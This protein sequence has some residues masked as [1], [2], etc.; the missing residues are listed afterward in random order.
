MSAQL[1]QLVFD[2]VL[3]KDAV[4]KI[5]STENVQTILQEHLGGIWAANI[6]VVFPAAWRLLFNAGHWTELSV[7][8]T[9]PQICLHRSS[10][11]SVLI[12][13]YFFISDV[14][15]ILLATPWETNPA[16]YSTSDLFYEF[17]LQ[18]CFLTGESEFL[19][20]LNKDPKNSLIANAK[21][22]VFS[23]VN[24]YWQWMVL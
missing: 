17:C 10:K 22:T 6:S 19:T 13:H 9:L 12:P 20:G 1:H 5:L 8:D 7:P 16:V 18:L 3:S 24:W 23:V 15:P 4:V 2:L 21:C 14:H 11:K